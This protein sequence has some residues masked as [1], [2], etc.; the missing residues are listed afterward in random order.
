LVLELFQIV[1]GIGELAAASVMVKSK[2]YFQ[3]LL[4]S[5]ENNINICRTTWQETMGKTAP[6]GASWTSTLYDRMT[7]S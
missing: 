2:H 7:D 1:I 6:N 5:S 3:A 4:I